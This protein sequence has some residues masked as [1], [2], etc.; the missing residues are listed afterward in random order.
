MKTNT[1]YILVKLLGH[2]QTLIF[3]IPQPDTSI[4]LSEGQK[5]AFPNAHRQASDSPIVQGITHHRHEGIGF[6]LPQSDAEKLPPTSTSNQQSV[7]ARIGM[8]NVDLVT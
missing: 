4:L 5:A 1:V 6:G 3:K 7:I 8:D 2:H